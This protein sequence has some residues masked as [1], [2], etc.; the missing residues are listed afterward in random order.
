MPDYGFHFGQPIWLW[1]LL[2]PLVVLLW[3]LLT[4]VRAQR[5]PIHRYADPHL[6]PHLT[7]SRDLSSGERWGRLLRWC[8]LWGLAVL[9]MAGP[10]WDYQ[11]MRLFRPGSELVVLL[12]ISRSM[13][14]EDVQPSRLGRARQEIFDLIDRNPAVR[15]GLVAFASTAHVISPITEDTQ[16]LRIA[17]P[18]L[19]SELVKLQ[20][21]RVSFALER[22]G[23]LLEGQDEDSSRAILMIT[24]GDFDEPNLET[25][26]RELAQRGIRLIILGVGTEEGG[27]VP[28]DDGSWLLDRQ[29]NQVQS[30]LDSDLL[31]DLAEAGNG[32]YLE[33]D[34][35]DSD[36]DRILELAVQRSG[37]QQASDEQ[38]RVWNER[39]YLLLIP[40]MLLLLPRF[41]RGVFGRGVNS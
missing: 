23:Q 22:A 29:R 11:D 7:A 38:T 30:R 4:R 35:R 33:A 10:R 34:Y 13:Q 25:Q 17:L 5:G 3:L 9:A 19:S 15:V 18:S 32:R 8:L 26:V 39:F 24:D 16:S 1:G 12:D 37:A 14:V 31:E 20:G 21:S 40:L 27:P 28:A 2:A 36:T 6:L 41:R